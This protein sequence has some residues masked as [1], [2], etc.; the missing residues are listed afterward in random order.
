MSDVMELVDEC[1]RAWHALGQSEMSPMGDPSLEVPEAGGARVGAYAQGCDR[2][3]G[4][5]GPDKG[6][7][8]SEAARG[9]SEDRG[10]R[11]SAG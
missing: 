10:V 1:A 7:P 8:L 6:I 11:L 3:A 4:E 9:A 5:L 2:G